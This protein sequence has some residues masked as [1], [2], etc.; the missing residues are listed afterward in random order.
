MEIISRLRRFH[1]VRYRDASGISGIGV[2][3]ERVLWSSGAV[4]LLWPE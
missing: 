4:A 3:A 2:V 1:Q